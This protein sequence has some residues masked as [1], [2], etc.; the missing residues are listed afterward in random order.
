MQ[1]NDDAP[2]TVFMNEVRP[3]SPS[4]WPTISPPFSPPNYEQPISPW[5]NQSMSENPSYMAAGRLEG[6][7]KTLPTISLVLGILGIVLFFC[8]YA[9]VPFGLGALATGF[10]G[11]NNINKNPMQYGGRNFAIAGMIMG[12]ISFIGLILVLLFAAIAR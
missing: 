7:D 8:C 1:V 9:G 11:L 3:T 12:G 4:N 6:P 10:I 5:Q 2:P